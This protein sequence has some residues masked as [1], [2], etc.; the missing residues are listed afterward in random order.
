MT[1][2][3]LRTEFFTKLSPMLD[4]EAM[5]TRLLAFVNVLWTESNAAP[6]QTR[7]E[8]KQHFLRLLVRG[9]TMPTVNNFI[10]QCS[11][12]TTK[13]SLTAKLPHSI[14][15]MERLDSCYR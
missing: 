9:A 4:D 11:T 3:E 8:K 15:I 12:A 1:T 10:R 14:D 7:E 6:S 2:T 5:M 13:D